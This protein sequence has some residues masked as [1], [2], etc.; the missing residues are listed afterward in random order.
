MRSFDDQIQTKLY[1]V[2]QTESRLFLVMEYLKGPE[3]F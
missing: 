3:L 2:Y 1:E